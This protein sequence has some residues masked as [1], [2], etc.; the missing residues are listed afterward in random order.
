MSR[1]LG[2]AERQ[3]L[4]ILHSY[5]GVG[6]DL[7][8]AWSA[9]GSFARKLVFPREYDSDAVRVGLFED[10]YVVE[11]RRMRREV[12]C[13]AAVLSRALRSLERKNLVCLFSAN[14]EERHDPCRWGPWVKFAGL[15]R[16]VI[17]VALTFKAGSVKCEQK[18]SDKVS[19]YIPRPEP[20]CPQ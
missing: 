4:T 20:W 2:K 1:G 11:L 18:Q 12:A 19:A 3:I 5:R 6:K 14:L 15:T 8:L 17:A 13:G 10:G 7:G 16:N 9:E